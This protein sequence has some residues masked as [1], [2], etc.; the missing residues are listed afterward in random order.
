VSKFLLSG[1]GWRVGYCPDAEVFKGLV[2]AE[3]WAIEL[4]HQEFEDFKRLSRQLIETIAAT[5]SEL[6]D[7]EN[8]TCSAQ[9][10]D[11]YLEAS[12][13]DDNF[14]IHLRLLNGRRAE[15]IW[16]SKAISQ[17]LTAIDASPQIL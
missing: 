16:T 9:T 12:G 6:S 4:N 1:E 13:V 10:E 3:N 2:G 8:L 5:Q 11:I 15:G 7:Q 17:L 14:T